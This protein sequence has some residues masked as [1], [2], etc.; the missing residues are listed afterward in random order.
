MTVVTAAT[1]THLAT[2]PPVIYGN[3]GPLHNT[4]VLEMRM[5]MNVGMLGGNLEGSNCP[6]SSF[7]RWRGPPPEGKRRAESTQPVRNRVGTAQ[8]S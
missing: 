8:A 5:K 4:P 2:A 6:I 7:Y 3:S 1:S